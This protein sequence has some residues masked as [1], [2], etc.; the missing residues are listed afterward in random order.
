M[1]PHDRGSVYG[2]MWNCWWS[3]YKLFGDIFSNGRNSEFIMRFYILLTVHHIMILGKWTTWR[4]ILYCALIFIFNSIHVSSTSCS[5]SGE[6]N[7]VN[8]TSGKLYILLTVRHVMI[9]GKRPTWHT[10][11]YYVFIFIFIFNSLHVSS[12]SCSSSGETNCVNTT[13]GKFYILL[14]VPHVMIIGKWP[15]W[16]TILYY[17]FIFIF[18]FNSL[19]VSNT[20]CSSTGETNCVNITSGNCHSASAMMSTMCTKH[21]DLK[22][23]IKINSL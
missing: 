2:L 21:A 19:H 16:R 5:S 18:T 14:T 9:L 1:L 6:R 7:C 12:T 11:L 10:I 4:T 3:C 23:K 22:I 17:V 13:S 20:S 15:T 8:T